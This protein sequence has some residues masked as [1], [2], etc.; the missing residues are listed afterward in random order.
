[1]VR[2]EASRVGLGGGHGLPVAGYTVCVCVCVCVCVTIML[3]FSEMS[4]EGRAGLW[5]SGEQCYV[6]RSDWR[7][8][9]KL[10]YSCS[11]RT[12]QGFL[13]CSSSPERASGRIN[14]MF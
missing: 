1:M 10:L 12:S 9:S 4:Q 6:P 7:V 8:E 3:W 5:A 13:I 2:N 14:L 11:Q